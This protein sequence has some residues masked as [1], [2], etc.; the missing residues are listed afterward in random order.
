MKLSVKQFQL[1]KVRLVKSRSQSPTGN[2]ELL[3]FVP[4][5]GLSI[6]RLGL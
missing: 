5:P 6:N 4:Q 2:P 1:L 3:Y